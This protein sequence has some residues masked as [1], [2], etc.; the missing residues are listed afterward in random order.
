M[1]WVTHPL[2]RTAVSPGATIE[3]GA[4]R[5]GSGN[6]SGT[7]VPPSRSGGTP[8][9]GWGGR[10]R[11]QV[12][13]RDQSHSSSSWLR[14]SPP[15]LEGLTSRR[16]RTCHRLPWRPA[17]EPARP[18]GAP[19][20]RR[21]RQIQL[22]RQQL[23]RRP[24]RLLPGRRLLSS[25]RERR[26]VEPRVR[27]L[28]LVRRR[29]GLR[30]PRGHPHPPSRQTGCPARRRNPHPSQQRP[31]RPSPFPPRPRRPTCRP[32]TRRRRL[33]PGNAS[34]WN[35]WCRPSR[36]WDCSSRPR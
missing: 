30:L 7:G 10:P 28:G 2:D 23:G 14:A 36:C 13:T 16:T 9:A 18:R 32:A 3:A 22:D 15:R 5:R 6:V 35:W 4:G 11:R 26:R 34:W 19:S 29:P 27:R 21:L 12:C 1:L 25:G 31:L 20:T 33:R 24:V 17:S 8:I